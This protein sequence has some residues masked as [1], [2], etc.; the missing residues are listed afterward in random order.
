MNI[1]SLKIHNFRSI[2]DAFFNLY[3]YSI[4]VGSNNAGKTNIFTALRIFYEDH[5]SFNERIDFP[6]FEIDDNESW[7]DIE[8]LLTDMESNNLKEEYKNPGNILK[9]RKYLKSD[10]KDKV[11]SKQSNIYAYEKSFLSDNLFYGAKNIGH[12]KLGSILYIPEVTKTDENLKLSGPSPLRNVISFVMSKVTKTS[13][14][15]ENLRKAFKDFNINFEQE[16]SKDGFSLTKLKEDINYELKEWDVEFGFNINPIK[17]EQIIKNLVSHYAVDKHLDGE[18]E[19][20]SFGQGLQRH[21]IYTLI[22]LSSQYVEIKTYKQKE[23]SPEFNF[24]LFEEP[25]AFLHPSQ[26]ENLNRSLRSLSSEQ[27]TQVVISTHSPFFIS[28]NIEEIS[29]LAKLKRENG[30]TQIFQVSENI[31][32]A[33]ISENNELALL[34][35]TKLNDPTIDSRTKEKIKRKLGD[36]DNIKRMEEE[37][38]RYQLWLDSERCCGFFAESVIIC[39]GASEKVFLEYLLKSKWTD[40]SERK[41]YVLD[42]MGKYNIHRYMNLFKEL[43]ITHSI[44]AD[45]DKNDNIHKIINQFI[46]DNRNPFTKGIYFFKNNI[47][48]FLEINPP[49][50]NRRDKKPLNIMWNYFK[51]KI[52]DEKLNELNKIIRDLI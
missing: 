32:N 38:I 6:K 21:L 42:S 25:E 9:V 43:G 39:E 4:L 31:R 22:K 18:I 29:S 13:E 20:K 48:A 2:K 12:T 11:K 3:D 7:I 37:S 46:L 17:P 40:L 26:Q 50:K 33:I 23:F 19:V 36:T 16:A 1:K 5:I 14:S 34:F 30:I 41:L 44:L 24:I 15:F 47:E 27:G 8:F 52:S 51:N 49:P 10:N 35:K 45:K 28:R